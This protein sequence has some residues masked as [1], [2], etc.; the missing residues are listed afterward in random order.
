MESNF[1]QRV[2]DVMNGVKAESY[3]GLSKLLKSPRHY[4]EYR[5]GVIEQTKAM[6][7]GIMF[8]MAC[9]EPEKFAE[10]YWV[11]DDLEK[12]DEIGGAKP[13]STKAYKE[14]VQEQDSLNSGRERVSKEDYDTFMRMSNALQFNSATKKLM[15]GLIEKEKAIEFEYDGFKIRG[16]IDG[17]GDSYI[18]DLKKAANSEFK[19][20]KWDIKDMNY[21][22]QGAI[23][24]HAVN[25]ADYY[26][27]YIDKACNIL[28]VK[29]SKE[30][31][32]QGW[33]KFETALSSFQECAE[34]DL[35]NGSYEF[36][37]GGYIVF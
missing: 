26:L 16:K 37:N 34:Q 35:W 15:A 32:E 27:I 23:Y 2:N 18:L 24:S 5:D 10:K 13:R 8:H 9:L 29:L 11:L 22:M 33:E 21:D 19:K 1:A 30:T 17:V 31:I 6:K 20:V 12:C 7:E 36:Y 25:K 4:K 14:W 3:S 28:V